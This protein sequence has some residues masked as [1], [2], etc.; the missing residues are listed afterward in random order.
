MTRYA[1]TLRL[2][3]G[4]SISAEM[5]YRA[6]FVF[7]AVG[8]VLTLGGALATLAVLYQHGYEMGGWSWPEAMLVVA[9]YTLLD[10][11]QRAVLAPNRQAISEHVQQGTLDFVLIKP[12]DAQ[13]WLSTRRLS[14][15][16]V[17]D[18]LLGL[19]LIVY[20]GSKL[21]TP[22]GVGGYAAGLIP[23]LLGAATLYALGYALATLTI[24]VTKAG[25]ITIAMQ[26]LLEA[27]RYPVPAYAPLFRVAF[28]FV[29]P[30]AFMTTVPAATM[31]GKTGLV[32]VI[33]SLGVAVGLLVACRWFWRF[34]L[35]SY[36]SASS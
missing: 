14:I 19:A 8:S 32:W 3:W 18:V 27:G 24:W 5:E 26:A 36:T 16:G 4:A 29:L 35:R 17:P 1:R 11:F 31:T 20:A 22:L 13:F 21:D 10:G 30:V 28:T 34:A 7:A 9:L 2:F 15:W 33:G 25:N 12:M 6:N 23:L